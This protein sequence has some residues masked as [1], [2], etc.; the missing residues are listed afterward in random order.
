MNSEII[1]AI[2]SVNFAE[3]EKHWKCFGSHFSE[4]EKQEL[5]TE[6]L[7][8]Y[9]SED[10][11]SFFVKV[12]NKIIDSR[13]ISLN[14]NIEHWAPT[15]LSLVVNKCSK[16]LFIYFCDKG[17]DI[18]F[19]GDYYAFETEE[20]IEQELKNSE[21]RYV[22]CLDFAHLKLSD[23]LTVDYN[24]SAPNKDKNI[25]HWSDIDENE[26]ITISKQE[27]YYLIEQSQYLHDI[28]HL[29]RLIDYIKTV[30]GKTY[31]DLR[32]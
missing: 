26:M 5:L 8:N 9:Y 10:K 21:T 15:F 20:T 11:F 31:E 19:I 18:N 24:Y 1:K 17:A 6:L 32:K 13:K 16:Q 14:F 28:I 25:N 23:L 12:F 3:F 2:E 22:T 4:K 7:D 27:F 30:G 29:S